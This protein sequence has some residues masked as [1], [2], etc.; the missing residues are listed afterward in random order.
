MITSTYK[1]TYTN[2]FSLAESTN[3]TFLDVNA[4]SSDQI[5]TY[6]SKANCISHYRLTI[7]GQHY[8]LQTN[9]M[10]YKPNTNKI[11]QLSVGGFDFSNNSI[12]KVS[13][14]YCFGSKFTNLMYCKF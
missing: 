2:Y 13:E 11:L 10:I 4:I 12:N 9:S 3:I 8:I 5:Y 1:C 14:T 6:W 7:D